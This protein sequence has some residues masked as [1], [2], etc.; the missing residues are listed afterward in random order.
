MLPLIRTDRRIPLR[1]SR[2]TPQTID[3]IPKTRRYVRDALI[4][5]GKGYHASANTPASGRPRIT[6]HDVG[7]TRDGAHE[8]GLSEIDGRAVGGNPDHSL[9][10]NE[11]RPTRER[12]RRLAH[13]CAR[14]GR[15]RLRPPLQ[16][17]CRRRGSPARSRR[18]TRPQG[19]MPRARIVALRQRRSSESRFP[20]RPARP[21]RRR[22]PARSRC[23]P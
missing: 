23:L 10:E 1:A 12:A 4:S 9:D 5:G 21:L 11:S 16:G 18:R 14:T 13:A 19:R 2:Y 22:L 20:A 17:R 7:D 8:H 3:S 15:A 6:E